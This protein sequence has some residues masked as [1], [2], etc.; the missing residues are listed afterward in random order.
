MNVD[1]K[2]ENKERDW[3]YSVGGAVGR[4]GGAN[5]LVFFYS[6]EY[7]PRASGGSI[8]RFRVPSMQG[9]HTAKAGFYLNHSFKA[10]NLG[11]GGGS[12]QGT[13]N[14]SN[15][16]NNPLDSGFGYANAVVGIFNQYA[17]QSQFIEGM[18]CT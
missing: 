8:A 2:A 17:Q 16:T 1:P 15:D 10:Q 4:P 12:F 6:H 13:V 3:G 11:A 7:R 5:K 9:R 18:G 14:F